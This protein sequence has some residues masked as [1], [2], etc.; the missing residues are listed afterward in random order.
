MIILLSLFFSRSPQQPHPPHWHPPSLH[1]HHPLPLL[2][3]GTT[4]TAADTNTTLTPLHCFHNQLPQSTIITSTASA[5]HP[6]TTATNHSPSPTTNCHRPPSPLSCLYHS[7]ATATATASTC[8]PPFSA[9]NCT[10]P[11]TTN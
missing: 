3:T 5:Y 9:F 7:T 10:Q 11:L 2:A 4:H 1:S 8:H 6:P